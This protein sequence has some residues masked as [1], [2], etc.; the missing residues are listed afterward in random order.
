MW[1][2]TSL[3]IIE[4]KNH[5][6][7]KNA[8]I[9]IFISI[10]LSSLFNQ[11][12]Y[13]NIIYF[14]CSF[15][16]IYSLLNI[17]NYK[18]SNLYKQLIVLITFIPISIL[19]Y[20]YIPKV[21]PWLNLNP[22]IVSET[23]LTNKLN[24]GD[25]SSLVQNEELVGRIYFGNEIP[26][27]K[28]RYWR[29]YVLDQY[30]NSTWTGKESIKNKD[31]ESLKFTYKNN[32]NTNVS[33]SWILEPNYKRKI[34]WSGKGIPSNEEIGISSKG[35]LYLNNPLIQRF[36]YSVITKANNWRKNIPYNY[37]R[38]IEISENKLLNRLG[39]KWYEESSSPEEIISKAE[40]FFKENRFRYSF[41]PGMMRK[42]NPYDDFSF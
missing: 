42:E 19:T 22:K 31:L 1:L 3:K 39:K 24:P 14:I 35:M 8:V 36:Q 5:I 30:K 13:S 20:I 25:I 4:V 11:Y 9:F 37:D 6:R 2:L 29:V 16:L 40:I 33:E 27:P 21:N 38:K 26:K 15:L 17:N 12:I 7:T 41:K 10:G 28:D 23:G 18:E 34:P 32:S